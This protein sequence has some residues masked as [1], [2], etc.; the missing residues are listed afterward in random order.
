ME[1]GTNA[2]ILRKNLQTNLIEDNDTYFPSTE[3]VHQNNSLPS[4]FKILCSSPDLNLLELNHPPY[5]NDEGD[6][7]EEDF[8]TTKTIIG[9]SNELDSLHSFKLWKRDGQKERPKSLPNESQELKNKSKHE[10]AMKSSF[11]DPSMRLEGLLLDSYNQKPIKVDNRSGTIDLDPFI[12]A[13]SNRN[14]NHRFVVDETTNISKTFIL[15]CSCKKSKC[16]RLH[17]VCFADLQQCGALCNCTECKNTVEFDKI[18][19][20]V[21]EKPS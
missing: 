2:N 6:S 4:D 1:P 10:M 3:T 8:G 13:N 19:D 12:K 7:L 11:E 18:R 15:K 14:N 9:D 20:F 5:Y 17:C 16:L 21:I